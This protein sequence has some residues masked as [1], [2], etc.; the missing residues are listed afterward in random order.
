MNFTFFL[1][2][3]YGNEQRVGVGGGG[4]GGV[5]NFLCVSVFST[6]GESTARAAF[7]STVLTG[8]N[9]KAGVEGREE[10]VSDV[11]IKEAVNSRLNLD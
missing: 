8:G 10:M 2:E 9:V 1:K 5:I 7:H 6:W 3:S 4:F 11:K